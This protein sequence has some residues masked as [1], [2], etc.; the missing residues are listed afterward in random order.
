[1]IFAIRN[2]E[3]TFMALPFAITARNCNLHARTA[4]LLSLIGC[5]LLA[6]PASAQ[7]AVGRVLRT[8]GEV[9]AVDP[10]GSTRPL[11]RGSEI[12]VT[13]VITTGAESSVQLRLSD[14]S[15]V[16]LNADASFSVDEYAFDGEGGA[17]DSVAMSMLRGSMRTISGSIGEAAGDTYQMN[18]PF[19][20]IGIRGTEY[21]VTVQ[22]NGRT[23]FIVF[24]GGISVTPA[25]GGPPSLLGLGGTSDAAEME[26]GVTIVELE[27]LP[28]ELQSVINAVIEAISDEELSNLPPPDQAVEIQLQL[29]QQD[30]AAVTGTPQTN[31]VATVTPAANAGAGG[32]LIDAT[33]NV[34]TA[35]TQEQLDAARRTVI[36]TISNV[37]PG[38]FDGSTRTGVSANR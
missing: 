25:G 20:S 23:F 9:S 21:G 28:A 34:L 11:A 26:D 1:M 5:L 19:A 15:L 32:Q 33:G 18:T 12:F 38:L 16:T 3:G 37:N 10:S 2:D 31:L 8:S 29:Q 27:Q 22:A 24:D 7:D 35:G 4:L 14:A 6:T 13:E 36:V 17:A 30:A